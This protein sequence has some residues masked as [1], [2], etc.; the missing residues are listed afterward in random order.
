MSIVLHL[1]NDGMTPEQ[2]EELR[3]IVRWDTDP[4]DGLRLHVAGFDSRG[5]R[6]TDVWDSREQC[7]R[8]F[9]TRLAEGIRDLGI[10]FNP[11]VNFVDAYAILEP[12]GA[13]ATA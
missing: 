11:V 6:V 13:V 4:P 8:F 1:H 9:E 5:I 7:D 10:P 3:E 2:Y 12:R